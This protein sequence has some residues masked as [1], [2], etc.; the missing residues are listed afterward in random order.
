MIL[1]TDEIDSLA[2]M[3]EQAITFKRLSI[4]SKW[5]VVIMHEDTYASLI[6]TAEKYNNWKQRKKQRKE[7]SEN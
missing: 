6:D 3:L 4:Y 2:I 5:P 7:K 1:T